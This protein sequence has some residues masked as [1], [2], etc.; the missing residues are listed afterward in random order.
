MNGLTSAFQTDFNHRSSGGFDEAVEGSVSNEPKNIMRKH[1]PFYLSILLASGC[2]RIDTILWEPKTTPGEWCQAMPCTK[3]PY[4]EMILDQP[5]STLLIYLLGGLWIWAG[6]R[7][8]KTRNG[9]KSRSWWSIT[10]VLGGLA[11]ISAG[12]SYQAFGFELK[13]VGREF[14]IWT[15]WWEIAYMVIEIASL[16][17]M[18]IAVAYSSTTNPLRKYLIF[19]AFTNSGVHLILTVV[20]AILSSRFLLSFELLVLF[21]MPAFLMYF[22]VNGI[23]YFRY[24]Q[25]MDLILLWAWILMVLTNVGYYAYLLLGYTQILWAKGIWFSE[26]DVLHVLV[27]CWVLY[28]GLVVSKNVKD[29][30]SETALTR[31]E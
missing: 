4:T 16:N 17:A 27:L 22:I 14:C 12:T 1:I 26:N 3:I 2:N 19:Y 10:M 23:G 15:N 30:S 11:A 8:W 5:L 29:A 31:S 24:K 28:V 18:L 9:Q 7:F 6:W 13:C 25:S 20:G 21:S